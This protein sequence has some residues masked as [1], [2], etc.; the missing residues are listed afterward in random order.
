VPFR[1]T[2][3]NPDF[4]DYYL[5]IEELPRRSI[6]NGIMFSKK[7]Y[8]R[9]EVAFSFTSCTS[10]QQIATIAGINRKKFEELLQGSAQ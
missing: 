6:K 8:C 1:T 10:M 9:G 5:C 4:L 7:K 2:L 3:C